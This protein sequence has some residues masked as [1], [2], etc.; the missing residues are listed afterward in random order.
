M[1]KNDQVRKESVR[2]AFMAFFK[3]IVLKSKLA[4]ILPVLT[5]NYMGKK[6]MRSI[7]R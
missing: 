6:Y 3:Q 5:G 7:I 2:E 4:E 1:V